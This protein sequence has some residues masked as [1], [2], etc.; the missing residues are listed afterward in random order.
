MRINQTYVRV[1]RSSVLLSPCYPAVAIA[2]VSSRL[3]LLWVFEPRYS[4]PSRAV[5]LSVYHRWWR[6]IYSAQDCHPSSARP[7]NFDHSASRRCRRQ[8]WCAVPWSATECPCCTS[9]G[10]LSASSHMRYEWWSAQTVIVLVVC[11]NHISLN[12]GQIY[13]MRTITIWNF[14]RVIFKFRCLQ[15]NLANPKI[16][17]VCGSI[18]VSNVYVVV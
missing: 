12:C 13:I 5:W 8:R 18:D 7:P 3:H 4:C 17:K 10:C 14:C 9:T 11:E 16:T 6:C 15:N 1:S 2:A